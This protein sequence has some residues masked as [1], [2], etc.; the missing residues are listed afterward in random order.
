MTQP[1]QRRTPLTWFDARS[2]MLFAAITISATAMS[3]QAQTTTPPDD[4]VGP[5]APVVGP[6]SPPSTEQTQHTG[7]QALKAMNMLETYR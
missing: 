6:A 7:Q 4:T 2:V 1:Q 3:A 5:T